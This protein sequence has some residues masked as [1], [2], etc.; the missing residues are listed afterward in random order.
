MKKTISAGLGGRNFSIEVDAYA[1]LEGYLNAYSS[2]LTQDSKDVMDEVEMRIADLLRE[3]MG[4]REVVDLD[5]VEKVVRQVG[6][7]E[8]DTASD[9]TSYATD[10][11]GR[12]VHKYYRDTDDSKIAGVCSGVALY[13]DVDVTIIRI[14]ALVLLICG[15]AGLWIYLIVCIVAPKAYTSSQKCELRGI[16]CTAENMRKYPDT[17]R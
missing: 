5:L 4:G 10:S 16:P 7:P 9:N 2:S 6:L 3:N 12:P 14:L 8:Y 1:R 15:T 13:F 11:Y 17:K